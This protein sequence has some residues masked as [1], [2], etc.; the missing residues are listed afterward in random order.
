MPSTLRS[1]KEEE[2]VP[3]GGAL[4]TCCAQRCVGGPRV[5]SQPIASC[6]FCNSDQ[7]SYLESS[8]LYL[9]PFCVCLPLLLHRDLLW[10]HLDHPVALY[11]DT[12]T[13]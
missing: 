1:T 10:L 4:S 6:P 8:A 11:R 12:A 5:E 3:K 9:S 2:V 7:R 13:S